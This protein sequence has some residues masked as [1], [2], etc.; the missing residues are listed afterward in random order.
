M[1]S[2]FKSTRSCFEHMVKLLRNSKTV[3]NF[4]FIA[5]KTQVKLERSQ[6]DL[7]IRTLLI[8]PITLT[9]KIHN[10]H[11]ILGQIWRT[12]QS[13]IPFE[14]VGTNLE[15]PYSSISDMFANVRFKDKGLL[16]HY[17]DRYFIKEFC[18]YQRRIWIHNTHDNFDYFCKRLEYILVKQS[19]IIIFLLFTH[20]RLWPHIICSD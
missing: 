3:K 15:T 10:H 8:L 13:N 1:P 2:G 18:K 14:W 17:I 16:D 9:S 11:I 5:L 4:K 19:L 7:E 12:F 20:K 6:I